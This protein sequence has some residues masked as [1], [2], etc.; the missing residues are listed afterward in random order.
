MTVEG[1]GTLA[2]SNADWMKLH[3][4]IDRSG[5]DVGSANGP[6][7]ERLLLDLNAGKPISEDEYKAAASELR[8]SFIRFMNCKNVLVDGL[9][10]VGSPMWTI[11]LLYPRTRWWRML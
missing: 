6:N 1:R 8:P 4:R 11:H 7:W 3:G 9:H 2:S 5:G 10:F